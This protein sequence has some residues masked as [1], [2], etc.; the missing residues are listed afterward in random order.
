MAWNV[1]PSSGELTL[2][3]EAGLICRAA[4]RFEAAR[5]IFSGVRAMRPASETPE[6]LLGT[7]CFGERRFDAAM[8]HYRTALRLNPRSAYGWAQLAESQIFVN[9]PKGAAVSAR[10]ALQLDPDGPFGNLASALLAYIAEGRRRHD[11]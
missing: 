8:E 5:E 11:D 4:R 3:L 1:S 2:L 10:K 6:I 7:V 9:D